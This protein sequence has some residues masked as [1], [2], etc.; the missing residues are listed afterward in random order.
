MADGHAVEISMLIFVLISLRRKFISQ[1]PTVAELPY[2]KNV[3]T[4]EINLYKSILTI[5]NVCG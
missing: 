3:M 4:T 1:K 5:Y 2:L